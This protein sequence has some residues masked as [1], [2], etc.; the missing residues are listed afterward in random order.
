M[1]PG[2]PRDAQPNP[3]CGPSQSRIPLNLWALISLKVEEQEVEKVGT[4]GS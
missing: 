4:E 3:V 1:F 2:G